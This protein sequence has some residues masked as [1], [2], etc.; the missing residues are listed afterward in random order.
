MFILNILL[1]VI[2][3][4]CPMQECW[5]YSVN[6]GIVPNLFPFGYWLQLFLSPKRV[7]R[8]RC[9]LWSSP[10]LH[11]P[12]SCKTRSRKAVVAMFVRSGYKEA[13][14]K[15]WGFF[16]SPLLL[17]SP[18]CLRHHLNSNNTPGGSL[19]SEFWCFPLFRTPLK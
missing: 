15:R 10:L 18:S 6:L 7:F 16:S 11:H 19:T 3:S 5:K 2:R 14:F 17:F 13:S 8:Q 12:T 9:N 4:F 1:I